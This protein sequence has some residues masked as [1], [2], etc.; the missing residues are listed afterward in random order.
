MRILAILMLAAILTL[1][2]SQAEESPL[3]N[4][5]V[6]IDLPASATEDQANVS[7]DGLRNI[8][9]IMNDRG[10]IGT[11][12]STQNVIETHSRLPLTRMGLDSFELAI[13]TNHSDEEI[14]PLSYSDQKS[15]LEKSISYVEACKICGRNNITVMGFMP[16]SFDQNTNTYKALDDLGI[17]YDAG[18]QSGLIFEAGHENDVWPYLVKGHKFYAAPLSTFTLEDKNVVLQDS[19]FKD[20]GLDASQWYDALAGKLDQIQGKDEPMIVSVDASLS[21]SG[22]YLDALNRFIEYAISKKASFVT[23]AQLVEM[24]KLGIRDVS[25]LPAPEET[26]E[27]KTCGENEGD[28]QPSISV[29]NLNQT[30]INQTINQTSSSD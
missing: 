15:L 17:Q 19:Y 29:V 23:T 13:S 11:V 8:Y 7:E 5:M 18:F 24:T 22:D 4:L 2:L 3:V 25:A 30:D 20:N 1:G 27:C 6:S 21:G 26:T 12:F 10:L 16:Q 14:S 9:K 28:L